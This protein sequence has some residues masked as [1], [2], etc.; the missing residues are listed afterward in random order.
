[1]AKQRKAKVAREKKSDQRIAPSLE[2]TIEAEKVTIQTFEEKAVQKA[3]EVRHALD[4]MP[5]WGGV[6]LLMLATTL[7]VNGID[8]TLFMGCGLAGILAMILE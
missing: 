5:F 4:R 7:Y 2:R 3:A 8:A 1:M 6:S